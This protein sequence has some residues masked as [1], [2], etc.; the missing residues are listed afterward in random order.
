[1]SV[2]GGDV[3]F[4]HNTERRDGCTAVSVIAWE[5]VPHSR[6]PIYSQPLDHM[7]NSIEDGERALSFILKSNSKTFYINNTIM[8]GHYA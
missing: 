6:V 7:I 4:D 1:M 8:M 3:I 2:F 5:H